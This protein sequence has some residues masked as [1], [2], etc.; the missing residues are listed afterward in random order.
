MEYLGFLVRSHNNIVESLLPEKRCR[1]GENAAKSL[2]NNE[3]LGIQQMHINTY[4]AAT[5]V[6]CPMIL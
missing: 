5:V 6:E 1:D 4:T 2:N 3:N